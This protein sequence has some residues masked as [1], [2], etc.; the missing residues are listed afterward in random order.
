[1][2]GVKERIKIGGSD[3]P[4]GFEE[5]GSKPIRIWACIRV[6]VTVGMMNF[7]PVERSIKVTKIQGAL[8]VELTD[9]EVPVSITSAAQEVKVE[10][11]ENCCLL[12]VVVKLA[13]IVLE[14][15]DFIA[16]VALI[17]TGMEESGILVT[18][19]S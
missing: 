9:M 5:R 11:M 18:F 2:K 16:P 15:L 13:A 19:N 10:G 3:S 12:I 4:S 17:S 8:R 14:N 7:S 1:M 6:H